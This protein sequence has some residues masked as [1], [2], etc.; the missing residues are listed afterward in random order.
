MMV[1]SSR[2]MSMKSFKTAVP[3]N[4]YIRGMGTCS[5]KTAMI[6]TIKI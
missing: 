3:G 6:K 5:I 2:S 4:W 1:E